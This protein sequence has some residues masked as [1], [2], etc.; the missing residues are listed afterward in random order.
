MKQ[1]TKKVTPIIYSVCV[2]I[3]ILL[4]TSRIQFS[5]WIWWTCLVVLVVWT[6]LQLILEIRRIRFS[7]R[8]E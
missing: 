6:L 8:K 7:E 5:S 2:L 3:F 1:W 4:S